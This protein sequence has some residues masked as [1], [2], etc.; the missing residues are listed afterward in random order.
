MLI[1]YIPIHCR[2]LISYLE[3]SAHNREIYRDVN[4]EH[5]QEGE[6]EEDKIYIPDYILNHDVQ[7]E[8]GVEDRDKSNF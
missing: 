1:S 2:V 8:D 6:A 7:Q 5:S 4:Y 3:G